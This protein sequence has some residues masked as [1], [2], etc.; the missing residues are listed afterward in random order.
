MVGLP[1]LLCGKPWSKTCFPLTDPRLAP[2]EN[3]SSVFTH[4]WTHLRKCGVQ[5]L[6]RG[7]STRRPGKQGIKLPIIRLAGG[8]SSS[9]AT[10]SIY[11]GFRNMNINMPFSGNRVLLFVSLAVSF[12]PCAYK[13]PLTQGQSCVGILVASGNISFNPQQYIILLSQNNP[14]YP[15]THWVCV[16]VH[17]CV[18]L[19]IIEELWLTAVYDFFRMWQ[20]VQCGRKEAMSHSTHTTRTQQLPLLPG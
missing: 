16:C 1:R 4:Q 12:S 5:C 6:A 19:C 10:N 11:L 8:S 17:A 15:M 13:L 9:W 3:C 2:A 7:H 14:L 20:C 18:C